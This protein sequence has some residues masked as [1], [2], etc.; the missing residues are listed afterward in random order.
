MQLDIPDND[1]RVLLELLRKLE[2]NKF[3]SE[4]GLE[5]Q[6]KRLK[7]NYPPARTLIRPVEFELL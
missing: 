4:F 7:M 3:L 2:D 6:A 5:F 1:R